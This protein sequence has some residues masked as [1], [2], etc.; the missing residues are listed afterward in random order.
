MKDLKKG[1]VKEGPKD[2]VGDNEK[3][4]KGRRIKTKSGLSRKDSYGRV[5]WSMSRPINGC[6]SS[7]NYSNL[8]RTI[9][10]RTLINVMLI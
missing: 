9:T 1:E 5:L 3:D 10:T 2:T 7:Q 8:R 4:I 6:C